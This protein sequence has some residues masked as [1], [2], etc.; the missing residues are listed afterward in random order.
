MRKLDFLENPIPFTNYLK[1]IKINYMFT[2]LAFLLSSNEFSAAEFTVFFQAWYKSTT[3]QKGEY[4]TTFISWDV[5]V[6]FLS[7]FT[8]R[9]LSHPRMTAIPHPQ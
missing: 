7:K 9:N 8:T 3:S 5:K 1:K 4:D 6:K 2:A